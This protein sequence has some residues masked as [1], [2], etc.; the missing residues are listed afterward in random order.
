MKQRTSRPIASDICFLDRDIR[1]A[2]LSKAALWGRAAI[3]RWHTKY[4]VNLISIRNDGQV[5]TH[6]DMPIQMPNRQ[7]SIIYPII[8]HLS[9]FADCRS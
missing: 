5:T 7:Q 4:V 3:A 2:T 6:C 1:A 8:C 9:T